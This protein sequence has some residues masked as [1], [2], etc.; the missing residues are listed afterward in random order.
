MRKP[1]IDNLMKNYKVPVKNLEYDEA[2]KNHLYHSYNSI[3][4]QTLYNLL[5]YFRGTNKNRMSKRHNTLSR[6]N[7]LD[8]DNNKFLFHIHLLLN[9]HILPD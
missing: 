7:T 9:H 3:P 6:Y 8:K 4:L 5:H 1:Q 2:R